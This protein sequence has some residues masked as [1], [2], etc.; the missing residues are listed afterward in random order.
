MDFPLRAVEGAIPP[1]QLHLP[2]NR[3]K[4]LGSK[5]IETYYIGMTAGTESVSYKVGMFKNAF[6]YLDT[7][8]VLCLL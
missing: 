7:L 6:L 4:T 3:G 5:I 8:E 2:E 1:R